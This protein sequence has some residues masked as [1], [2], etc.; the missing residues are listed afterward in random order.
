[1]ENVSAFKKDLKIINYLYEAVRR[2][3]KLFNIKYFPVLISGHKVVI[4]TVNQVDISVINYVFRDRYHRPYI[5]IIND[6]PVILDLGVNIGCSILDLKKE[7]PS[8]KI[9][10]CEMDFEN[11]ELAIKNCA[12]LKDV[13][14]INK[15]VWYKDTLVSYYKG[16][17]SYSN[18]DAYTI[19]K[20]N[21]NNASF[22]SAIKVNSIT[23]N[24]IILL[25]E[26]KNIDYVKMD[27]EGA[28]LEVMTMNN[29]WLQI[30]KQIK[31]EYHRGEND[32]DDINRVL[33]SYGFNSFITFQNPSAVIAY[34][35]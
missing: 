31:I 19:I 26:I 23:I 2:L 12:K 27:I 15:A 33:L 10:G 24:S 25:Y 28:E 6:N 3:L 35:N 4:R 11:Y 9:I 14:L 32:A 18:P 7:Y 8:A 16:K 1:M 30:V 5:Q 21:G 13:E 17:D 22:E 29:E 34:K 20:D